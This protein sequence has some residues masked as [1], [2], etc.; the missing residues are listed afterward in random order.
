MI[1]VVSTLASVWLASGFIS[2]ANGL[3][4]EKRPDQGGT[5]SAQPVLLWA[6]HLPGAVPNVAAPTEPGAPVVSGDRIFVGYSG[7]NAL[8]VLDREDGR[9][10]TQL[11]T[12]AP[13]SCAPIVQGDSLIVADSAG[14]TAGWTKHG[15]EW[16]QTWEHFSGAPIVSTPTVREGT[17][18]VTN[19]DELVFALDSVSGQLKWRYEHRLDAARST[20]LELFGAPAAGVDGEFVYSGFSDGFL[21]AID[22]ATGSERWTALV[23]EGTYPDIIAP[24]IPLEDGGVVVAG[25]SKPLERLDPK[26]R[27]PSWRI[28]VG[29]AAGPAIAGETMYHPGSD[30]K[31]RRVDTRTGTIAW[32]WDSGTTG[33]L[34]TP[35]L[36]PQGVLVASSD[37]TVYMIDPD[38]GAVRWTLDPGPLLTGFASAPAVAG[39]NIYALSNGGVL[40]ALRGRA[41]SARP[42][43]LPWVSR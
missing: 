12:R 21:A 36:T 19:V 38:T 15:T 27:T 37:T 33:P 10:V 8:L 40:Y 43:S 29:S 23:G 31:L 11:A 16:T 28:E 41:N 25:Y 6:V 3:E 18:F 26:T 42:P 39:D 1:P 32:T 30:G 14:Y 7:V 20:E 17:V 9:V 4:G 13:V 5:L 24:A 2:H 22:R 35:E 34:L